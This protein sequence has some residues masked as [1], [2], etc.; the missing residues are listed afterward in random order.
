MQAHGSANVTFDIDVLYARDSENLRSLV[1]AL[2]PLQP[3]LR[4][5]PPDLPFHFDERTLQNALNLTLSTDL[6]ALDI[7]ADAPGGPIDG[8]F[9]R[10]ELK[11]LFGIPVRVASIDDLIAMKEA[12]GRPKDIAHLYELRALKKLIDQGS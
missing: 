5:A 1:E 3:K 9:E 6:G 4:N 12:A 2:A 10:S 11:E 8:V 7:L